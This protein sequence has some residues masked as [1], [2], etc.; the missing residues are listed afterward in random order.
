[1]TTEPTLIVAT[2]APG[3][4]HLIFNRPD[5]HNAYDVPTFAA[6][7]EQLDRAATD[8]DIRAIV[9]SARGGRAFSAGFDIHEMAGFD[10]DTMRRAF[11]TRDPVFGRVAAHPLPI[12]AAIDGICFGAGALLALA[13]DMRIATPGFRFKVTAVGYGCA[14]AT[15]SLP[16][17]VGAPRA[18]AILMTGQVVEA[19]EAERIGLVN[20]IV[21]ASELDARAVALASAIAA[22][23][24]QGIKGIKTL[25]DGSLTRSPVEGWQAEYDWMIASMVGAPGGDETFGKFL[26]DHDHHKR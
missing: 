2:P 10:A 14:N 9:I 25:V 8:P 11:E 13:C 3:V 18:K 4:L 17:A 19:E 21:E 26:S 20:A 5:V 15:W 24:P 16:R 12:I 1:M 22:H 23:P 6:F 7:A